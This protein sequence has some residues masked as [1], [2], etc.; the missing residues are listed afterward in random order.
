MYIIIH[1]ACSHSFFSLLINEVS[2]NQV[3]ATSGSVVWPLDCAQSALTASYAIL[4]A[5]ELYG[6][7]C[8]HGSRL[9]PE[10]IGA[11]AKYPVVDYQFW[12]R[13]GSWSHCPACGFF[14]FN[15]PVLQGPCVST[16]SYFAEAM[17]ALRESYEGTQ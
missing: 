5:A 11:P 15:K 6:Q 9:A 3:A 7:Q 4:K 14:F 2:N 17:P 8:W 16:A 12:V 13:Y 1:H 10:Q